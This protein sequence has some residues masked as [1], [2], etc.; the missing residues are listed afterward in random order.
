MAVGLSGARAHLIRFWSLGAQKAVRCG[1]GG[2]LVTRS[3]THTTPHT[4]P[5]VRLAARAEGALSARAGGRG[6]SARA[7]G[8]EQAQGWGARAAEDWGLG[9]LPA[10]CG[11]RRRR[12][13]GQGARGRGGC[14]GSGR[15]AGPLPTVHYSMALPG[16]PESPRGAPRKA[17][18]LLEMGA[19]CLDSDIIL[20][21]TSHLLRR[22][23][24]VRTGGARLAAL[25]LSRDFAAQHGETRQVPGRV[26]HVAWRPHFPGLVLLDSSSLVQAALGPKP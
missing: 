21:F 20:G 23:G 3:P 19:L 6:W 22:R 4:G 14:G 18:S 8:A 26:R 25:T 12:A 24:K 13:R 5:R 9:G 2:I 15:R 7:R 11:T 16:S 1:P 10:P 17:P